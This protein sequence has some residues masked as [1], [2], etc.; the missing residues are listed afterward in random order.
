MLCIDCGI[1]AVLSHGRCYRC[2]PIAR[3][4][5]VIVVRAYRREPAPCSVEGCGAIATLQGLCR[6]HYQ[7]AYRHGS[8]DVCYRKVNHGR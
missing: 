1:R 6:K 8:P 3:D 5:G 4:A 7:R 2:Y